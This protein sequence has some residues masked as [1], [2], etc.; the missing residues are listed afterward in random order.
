MIADNDM[1]S[2]DD[3]IPW[4]P[5][6]GDEGLD[7]SHEGGKYEALQGLSRTMAD[8]SGFRYVDPKTRHDRIELQTSHWDMQMDWLV[9]AYLDYRSR[10]SGNGIPSLASVVSNEDPSLNAVPVLTNIELIDTFFRRQDSFQAS[11]S[12]RYPNKTLI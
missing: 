2:Y 8:L 4:V 6:P 9:N 7:L 1:I 11:L 3:S 5:A 10:D 12:H